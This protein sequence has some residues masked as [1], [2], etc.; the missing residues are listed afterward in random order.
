M[1]TGAAEPEYWKGRG[2]SAFPETTSVHS[3]SLPNGHGEFPEGCILPAQWAVLEEQD[4]GLSRTQN[5]N[6]EDRYG[7]GTYPCGKKIDLA[8][9]PPTHTTINSR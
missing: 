3:T 6:K 4:A 1:T 7:A 8:P 2:E 9:L 5:A